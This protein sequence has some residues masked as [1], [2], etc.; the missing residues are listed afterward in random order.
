MEGWIMALVSRSAR[1]IAAVVLATASSVL[2][3][4]APKVDKSADNISEQVVPQ[5]LIRADYAQE[6]AMAWVKTVLSAECMPPKDARFFLVPHRAD[7]DCDT[8]GLSYV[9]D[10]LRIDITQ[11]QNFMSVQVSRPSWSKRTRPS[12]A[13]IQA[14]A[15][16]LFQKGDGLELAQEPGDNADVQQGG[17]R[18]PPRHGDP[19]FK[20]IR[21]RQDGGRIVFWFLKHPGEPVMAALTGD[22]HGNRH[23]FTPDPTVKRKQG[24]AQ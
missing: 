16:L 5:E 20:R 2:L 19:W 23:W 21:W 10:N 12:F 22:L 7:D 14:T 24:G 3:F 17:L 1:A 11:I 4:G 13:D 6:G 8:A 9:V 15:R 18:S